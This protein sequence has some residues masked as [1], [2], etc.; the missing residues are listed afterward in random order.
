MA[1]RPI[2]KFKS[3]SLEAAIWFN[4]RENNGEIVGFKTVSLKKSWK[5]KEKDVWRNET[6]NIRKQDIAKLLVILN[7]VQEE[8]LLNK[9]DNENE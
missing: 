1:N 9:E 6:L 5:D 7:K 4:E 3:G 2:K 8:L